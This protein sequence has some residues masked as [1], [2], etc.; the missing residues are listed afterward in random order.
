MTYR[1][2]LTAIVA[3]FLSVA[4]ALGASIQDV[5][6]LVS[7]SAYTDVHVN[8]LYTHAGNNRGYGAQHDL[9]RTNIYNAFANFG[10]NPVLSPFNYYGTT[11]YNVVATLPGTVNPSQVYI[12]GA[13]FDS[14]SNP[15][16]D[17]NGSGTAGVM[18]L[19]RI[20]SRRRF[21]ATI[22]FIAFDREE[23]GL[24]GSTAY[25]NAHRMDD[26]RGM[27]S[28]DMIAYNPEGPHHDKAYIYGRTASNPIKNDLATAFAAYGS[29]IG[30]EIGGDLPYSDQAP[31]EANGKQA[32]LLIE[33]AEE[34]NPYYHQAADNIDTP[35]YIDYEYATKMTRGVAGWAATKAGMASLVNGIWKAAGSGNWDRSGNWNG[36]VPQFV[37]DSATF[38]SAIT[39]PAQVTLDG[40]KTVSGLTFQNVKSY[41]IV[42]GAGGGHLTLQSGSGTVPLTVAAGS[43]LIATPISLGSGV[44]V[45]VASESGLNISGDVGE[46]S[47]GLSLTKTGPGRLVL[48]G[49]CSY[50]GLTNVDEGVLR[51]DGADMA[52]GAVI[53]VAEGATLEVA[54]GAL[55]IGAIEGQGTTLVG[56][57]ATSLTVQSIVQGSLVIGATLGAAL[58]PST[59][60][61][62][63]AVPEPS[64]LALMGMGGVGLFEFAR[65]RRKM[66]LRS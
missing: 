14:A 48:Q 25:A 10:L 64:A 2:S 37:G 29:G 24:I 4:S 45:G 56:G 18:E 11:Y 17:D 21:D 50:T 33:H 1:S 52:H 13:H 41:S 28:L 60:D 58:Q 57:D 16:A 7:Q 40:E 23:Q 19:A 36:G 39:A 31:F 8:S 46:S 35:N 54:A 65:R 9:A 30:T 42:P 3:L 20:L 51:L 38:G 34:V 63:H 26:I 61:A 43:H 5:A 32:C 27:V 44:S 53:D 12:V 15:G 47:P 59:A 6:G 49:D 66:V 22:V 55:S 62:V